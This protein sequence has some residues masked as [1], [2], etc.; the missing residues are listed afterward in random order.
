V[1]VAGAATGPETIDDSISQ[2]HAAA[3]AALGFLQ[4]QRASA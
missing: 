2:G 4:P 1:F 3:L